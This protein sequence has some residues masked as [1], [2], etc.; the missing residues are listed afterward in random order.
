[1]HLGLSAL[2]AGALLLVMY[3]LWYPPPYFALMGGATLVLLIAGCDVV[4]GP[5]ITLIIFRS[6]K[7]GL[8]LDLAMIGVM[9]AAALSYGIYTMFESRPVFTVFV[10]DRFEVVAANDLR[11]EALAKAS[12]PEFASLS[13]TGPR[14]VGATLPTDRQEQ[15]D[16]AMRAAGGG[17]DIKNLPRFYVP[18]D[19]VARNAAHHAQSLEAL[20]NKKPENAAKLAAA[21][22]DVASAEKQAGYLPL[23]GRFRDMSMIV[24][25]DTGR[26]RTIV[27]AYPW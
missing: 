11:S 13:L 14:V 27:D 2:V 12:A 24:D 7:K 8:K 19:A 17:E 16:I 21:L 1:M 6:G 22:K 23:A 5:L 25:K 20:A 18:Y 26:I 9:Q 10:V 3:A 15:M 4:L